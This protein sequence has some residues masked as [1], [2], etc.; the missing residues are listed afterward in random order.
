MI[1]RHSSLMRPAAA[2]KGGRVARWKLAAVAGAVSVVVFTVAATAQTLPTPPPARSKPVAKPQV[3]ITTG[4]APQA[5]VVATDGK[6]P[7]AS[8]GEVVARMGTSE[9]REDAVRAFV[10][11]LSEGDR[12]TIAREPEA[13]TRAIRALLANQ[14]VLNEALAKHWD[15]QPA[16]VQQL[17][18][19]RDN[20]LVQ[21]YLQSVSAPPQDYPSEPELQ[22]AYE[23]NKTSF[24]MPRQYLVAQIFVAAPKDADK[25]V[26]DK[27]KGRIDEIARQLRQPNADFAA[28]ARASS[29]AR[30]S[31]EK[32]GEIGWLAETQLRGDI[33]SQITG[34]AKGALSEPVR[35]DDGWQ[36]LKLVDTKAATT[37]SFAEVRDALRQRVRD[38]RAAENRRAFLADMLKQNPPAINELTLA[39]VVGDITQAA[40]R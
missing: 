17:R 25:A 7:V 35:L 10:A 34:L 3:P 4:V 23:A 18:Q 26:Q 40:S 28:I 1:V 33:K 38:E 32:G 37:A 15:Q 36:I 16:V 11:G 20:A 30:Q 6:P 24:M 39:R 29:E 9:V 5:E 31:A 22:S 2:G 21:T 19:L 27:A 8:A 12:A 14:L 13:M